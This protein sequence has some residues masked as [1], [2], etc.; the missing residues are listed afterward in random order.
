MIVIFNVAIKIKFVY[1]NC[2]VALIVI[3]I[4][5][6]SVVKSTHFVSTNFVLTSPNY[7]EAKEKISFD[8][9]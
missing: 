5:K 8:N 3:S 6:Y 9:L 4:P 1:L 2:E 7:S